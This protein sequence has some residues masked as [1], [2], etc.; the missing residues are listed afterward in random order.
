M[1][2]LTYDVWQKVV[3]NIKLSISPESYDLWISPLKPLSFE[4]NTFSL[5]VPNAYFSKW[6]EKNHQKNIEKVLSGLYSQNVILELKLMDCTVKS[7]NEAIDISSS[8]KSRFLEKLQTFDTFSNHKNFKD[9][10]NS[11]YTFDVF[12]VGNSN[13]YVHGC[14]ELVS[15]K[16]GEIYNPLFIYGGVGLG[17]THVLHA[18]GNKMKEEHPSFKILYATCEKFVSDYTEAIRFNKD[19]SVFKNKYRNLDCILLDDVQFLIGKGSSQEEFFNMFNSLRNL[20]KQI[21]ISSDRPPKELSGIEERLISR[22]EWGNIADIQPPDYETRVAILNKKMNENGLQVSDEI[23]AYIASQIKSNI[24]QLEGCLLK[25]SSF[26][27]VTKTNLDIHTTKKILKDIIRTEHNVKVDISNI[28][29]VVAEKYHIDVRDMKSKKR[30]DALA[31]PRQI[32]MYLSRTMSDEFST[33]TIGEAF[34]RDHTTVMHACKKIKEKLNSD[35]FFAAQVNEII[36][37]IKS[38]D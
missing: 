4:N 28:Q 22:F 14:S 30:T 19:I 17:K 7:N 23:I 21:V 32:A 9:Q 16:P 24:R 33:T 12:V 31:F 3:D 15:S 18:I 26:A 27:M 5:G 25:V 13:R 2:D 36:K 20:N 37:E 11:K 34:G 10:I 6:V 35:P 1:N 38:L 8:S 29:K